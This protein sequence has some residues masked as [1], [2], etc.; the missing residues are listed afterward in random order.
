MPSVEE[1]TMAQIAMGRR[2]TEPQE[3]PK[4]KFSPGD[5]VQLKSGSP[6]FTV[7]KVSGFG[8]YN[9]EASFWDAIKNQ[10]VNVSLREALLERVS[11]KK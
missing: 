7:A 2:T 3:V 10:V 11:T 9:I 6:P 1:M 8:D 4:C 5:L